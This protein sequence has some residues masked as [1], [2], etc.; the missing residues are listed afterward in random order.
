M[1]RIIGSI[2]LVHFAAAVSA[3]QPVDCDKAIELGQGESK[4]LRLSGY[5]EIEIS[6]TDSL[7]VHWFRTEHHTCWLKLPVK[8]NG[9][10]TL[11]I[12]ESGEP[13]LKIDFLLFKYNGEGFCNDVKQKKVMPVRTNLAQPDAGKR[14][15]TGL[16]TG[17]KDEFVAAT[18][19]STYSRSIKVK[20]GE[21][22]YLVIDSDSKTGGNIMAG[23]QV[24][25]IDGSGKSPMNLEKKD[26][27]APVVP[28]HIRVVDDATGL[29]VIA[30][31]S[32][33]DLNPIEAVRAEA[34]EFKAEL[35]SSQSIRVDCNAP[36]Y[37][38]FSQG[39]MA[40]ALD[41]NNP[42][43]FQPV[44]VEI[45]MKKLKEGDKVAL[46]NIRFQPDKAEFMG[47]SYP[48]LQSLTKFLESNPSVHIEIG[49]HINGPDGASG[50]GKAMSKRRAKAVYDYLI[51][52]GIDKSRLKYKGYGNSQMIWPEPKNER[53]AEEN[54]RVEIKILK[55]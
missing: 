48:A 4:Y 23:W 31:I 21:V 43:T 44:S 6:D 52:R 47:G 38:F 12:E 46:R 24:T 40:P 30:K 2:I 32:I 7:P 11:D 45:R 27:S 51:K 36:G 55:E 26:L 54:R 35:G 15:R 37:M 19:N 9:E 16:S 41:R 33:E 20:A 29:P 22:Y 3:Q 28:L 5:G 18:S 14:E 39:I 13:G 50:A 8:S 49:G 25:E 42:S 53:Q 17:I 34:S 1:R 10:L